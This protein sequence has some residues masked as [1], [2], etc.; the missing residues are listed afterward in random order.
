[1]A[2]V[3]WRWVKNQSQT[4]S[5]IRVPSLG[6]LACMICFGPSLNCLRLFFNAFFLLFALQL[7]NVKFWS[8]YALF[9]FL[10]QFLLCYIP[11]LH[12]SYSHQLHLFQSCLLLLIFLGLFV[13]YFLLLLLLCWAV[14][15]L[16]TLSFVFVPLSLV[17]SFAPAVGCS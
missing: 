1:M 9:L 13:L 7:F 14:L 15:K 3:L 8:H 6:L 12:I 10:L 16:L 17:V 5:P 4:L 11:F 2:F